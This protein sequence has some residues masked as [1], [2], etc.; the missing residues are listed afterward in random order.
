MSFIIFSIFGLFKAKHIYTEISKSLYRGK[1]KVCV[2]LRDFKMFSILIKYK[3]SKI[4]KS[5]ARI[6]S[7]IKGI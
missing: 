1:K 7:Y 5:G 2:C 3:C 4:K 6:K